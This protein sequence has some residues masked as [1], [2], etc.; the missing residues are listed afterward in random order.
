MV[1]KPRRTCGLDGSVLENPPLMAEPHHSIEFFL[2]NG[3]GWQRLGAT[4]MFF[5][6]TTP[7]ILCGLMIAY[8]IWRSVIGY[9]QIDGWT[10][11]IVMPFGI[12]FAPVLFYLGWYFQ[13]RA[14]DEH[15]A[16]EAAMGGR[17][18]A[19]C[20]TLYGFLAI[21]TIGLAIAGALGTAL[22]DSDIVL[23]TWGG[24]ALVGIGLLSGLF[25]SLRGDVQM[26]ASGRLIVKPTGIALA[27]FSPVWL[28]PCAV[29]IRHQ[30]WIQLR[31]ATIMFL[32]FLVPGCMSIWLS[33]RKR[34]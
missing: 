10:F 29:A 4:L 9:G 33:D 34:H 24:M 6:T 26:F 22:I 13:A 8:Q 12:L 11:F 2:H 7:L 16:L 27:M 23:I 20:A 25:R 14:K 3:S 30:D 19:F 32:I 5:L 17:F 1:R 28:Y 31:G 18:R 21:V 15:V